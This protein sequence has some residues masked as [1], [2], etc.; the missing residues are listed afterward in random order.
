MEGHYLT[1]SSYADAGDTAWIYNSMSVLA[2]TNLFL[3]LVQVG[4]DSAKCRVKNAWHGAV[5]LQG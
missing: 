5:P 4:L 3:K 2:P 1:E